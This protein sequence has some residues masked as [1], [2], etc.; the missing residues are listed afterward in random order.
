MKAYIYFLQLVLLSSSLAFAESEQNAKELFNQFSDRIFKVRVLELSSGNQASIGSGFQIGDQGR[1]ITNFHVVSEYV[2]HPDRYKIVIENKG[3]EN[4]DLEII[5]F[6]VV[7]DLAILQSND[8]QAVSIPLADKLPAKGEPI[9]SLGNPH[10]L[11]LSVVPGTFNGITSYSLY[12]R[13]HISGA[14]NSGMSGGPTLDKF[15]RVIGVNV[16]SSGNQVGFLIPLEHLRFF[17]DRSESLWLESNI[18]EQTIRDQLYENQENIYQELLAKDWKTSKLGQVII[19]QE[20]AQYIQ[21]WGEN[22][23]QDDQKY[24][25]IQSDCLANESIYISRGFNTG[26]ILLQY[27]WIE[28]QELNPFQFYT[29]LTLEG[30]AMS[31]DNNASEDDV[32]KFKC[33]EGFVKA[34]PNDQALAVSKVAFCAREYKKYIGIYDVMFLSMSVQDNNRSLLGHFSISGVSEDTALKFLAKYFNGIT[35]Q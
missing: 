2:H 10:D 15:G 31:P 5:N 9:F 34:A 35:W 17:I 3:G 16:A 25:Y 14:I 8:V 13:I 26:T 12:G 21:C 20:I 4:F 11:G 23:H 32:T 6:D 1:I 24:E 18:Y 33:H 19:P 29:L 30:T 7:N 28:S 22:Y 27:A